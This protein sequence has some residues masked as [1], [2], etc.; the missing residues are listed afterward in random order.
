MSHKK[1]KRFVQSE[2]TIVKASVKILL[3]NPSAG[4]SE[5]A[6]AANVGRAT[7]YRHFKTREVLFRKIAKTCMEEIQ[8]A[9][10]PTESLNGRVAIEA[11]IDILVPLAD[12][13]HFLANLWS[14]VE[15]D[16]ELSQIDGQQIK[17]L[18]VLIKQA[19]TNG[20]IGRQLPNEW[21]AAFFDSILYTA[22]SMVQTGEITSKNASKHAK[23][24]FFNGC[25]K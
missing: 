4:M 20:E 24:S 22:W 19:K 11:L 21:L 5:I 9:S 2:L 16:E 12:K 17:E 8:I 7:M 1:D 15:Q 10:Q 18:L 13:Y 3:N 6:T 23:Q 25:K 14:L